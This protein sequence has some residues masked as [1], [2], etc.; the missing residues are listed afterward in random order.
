MGVC[1]AIQPN[2]DNETIV[3]RE[4]FGWAIVADESSRLGIGGNWWSVWP[5]PIVNPEEEWND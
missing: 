5:D 1:H 4:S 3:V 2:G